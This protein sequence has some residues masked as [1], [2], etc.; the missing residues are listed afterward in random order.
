[1][2]RVRSARDSA[3][4]M[5]ASLSPAP[6]RATTVSRCRTLPLRP[7]L[8]TRAWSPPSALPR[9]RRGDRRGVRGPRRRAG[10]GRGRCHR[11]GPRAGGGNRSPGR[12]GR[13]AGRPAGRGRRRQPGAAGLHRRPAA[14]ALAAGGP[15]GAAHRRA[16][17]RGGAGR[18]RSTAGDRP[19]RRGGGPGRARR[20]R[21]SPVAGCRSS[22][23]RCAPAPARPRWRSPRRPVDPGLLAALREALEP[24]RLVAARLL[25][26]P[27][28]LVVGVT[29]RRRLEPAALA[30]L[31]DRVR[32]VLGQRVPPAGLGLAEV[33]A[34]G[35]GLPLVRRSRFR[36]R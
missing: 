2:Q 25:E 10:A 15:A 18:G 16:G 31:A 27:D 11:H 6:R 26:G 35:P 12:V 36:R 4:I 1:M 14:A 32:A 20:S 17:V 3:W 9:F 28:G 30:A 19:R 23:A 33:A 8:P 21:L 29:G 34:T 22:A 7:E 24:E 5:R 13:R